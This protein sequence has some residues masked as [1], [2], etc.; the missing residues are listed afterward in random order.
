MWLLHDSFHFR[1]DPMDRSIVALAACSFVAVLVMS[2]PAAAEIF[3]WDDE[4]GNRHLTNDINQVPAQYRDQALADDAGRKA[5]N[6]RI[7]MIDA[8]PSAGDSGG[9]DGTAPRGVPAAASTSPQQN[10]NPM[11][12]GQSEMWWRQ[13][14]LQL[15]RNVAAAKNALA[16]AEDRG[17]DSNSVTVG[18]RRGSAGRGGSPSRAGGRR[19]RGRTGGSDSGDYTEYSYERDLDELEVAVGDAERAYRDF[20]DQARRAEVPHGWLRR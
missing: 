15:Q 2:S 16:A 19:H 5:T 8:P 7:N 12:G 11:P 3:R 1:R 6:A 13:T 10:A 9:A 14:S 17:D 20:H 4:D 18:R